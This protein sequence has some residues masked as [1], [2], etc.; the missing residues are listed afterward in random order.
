MIT[1]HTTQAQGTQQS[2]GPLG[3]G[4]RMVVGIGVVA[5]ALLITLALFASQASWLVATGGLSLL[6]DVRA[7]VAQ[8][9]ETLGLS[10]TSS[11]MAMHSYPLG[12][13]LPLGANV[14]E[15]PA[16]VSDYLR[17]DSRSA[18]SRTQPSQLGIDLPQGAD[19]RQLP[20][21][22]TDYIRRQQNESRIA[23]PTAVLG[24]TLPS[25]TQ[26]TDLPAGMRDYLRSKQ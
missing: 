10:D 13:D 19:A 4:R 25:G 23:A 21:G 15:L 7:L 17:P 1:K 20:Q 16:G 24:I 11:P 2:A 22:L 14:G 8:L 3:W 18:S 5:S 12:I 9:A 26:Y 6:G